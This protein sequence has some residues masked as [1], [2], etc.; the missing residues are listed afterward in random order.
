LIFRVAEL[1]ACH[2]SLL[3]ASVGGLVDFFVLFFGGVDIDEK[4]ERIEGEQE[5]DRNDDEFH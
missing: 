4:R 1:W 5:T 2:A 3:G